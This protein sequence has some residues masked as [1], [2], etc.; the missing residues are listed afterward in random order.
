MS[1]LMRVVLPWPPK[2]LSPNSRAHWATQSRVRASYKR[3]C[4]ICAQ[5][6]GIFK[7]SEPTSKFDVRVIFYP[8][9]RRH[10]DRDNM[11]ASIKYG[12]DSIAEAM[13]VNDRL[14]CP[15]YEFS[16]RH[17]L[18]VV[19]VTF[20][21]HRGEPEP[22]AG[23]TRIDPMAPDAVALLFSGEGVGD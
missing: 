11:A 2:E 23:V 8:P 21:Y 16:E 1:S 15:S 19:G 9:D 7:V 5:N 14:F 18:G 12:L 20:D 17:F 10:R 22:T 13:G 6:S 4:H 3:A